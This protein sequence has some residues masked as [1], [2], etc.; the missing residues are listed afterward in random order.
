MA[1][2][3]KQKFAFNG[4]FGGLNELSPRSRRSM[5]QPSNSFNMEL[6]GGYL[7]PRRGYKQLVPN[8]TESDPIISMHPI[9]S[10]DETMHDNVIAQIFGD[11]TV[12]FKR[13][14]RAVEG[15]SSGGDELETLTSGTS[16]GG[17]AWAWDFFGLGR[18]SYADSGGWSMI[19]AGGK[20]LGIITALR[21]DDTSS[22]NKL[23]WLDKTQG[24]L[25]RSDTD[26]S[27]S[28]VLLY[29]LQSPF[30]LALDISNEMIYFTE[31]DAHRISRCKFNGGEHQVIYN[32]QRDGIHSPQWCDYDGTNNE[33][34]WTQRGGGSFLSGVLKA[35]NVGAGTITQ[36]FDKNTTGLQLER[37]WRGIAL[38]ENGGTDTDVFFVSAGSHAVWKYDKDVDSASMIVALST[39]STRKASPQD[40]RIDDG[41]KLYILS[42]GLYTHSNPF[43]RGLD[44][45][46][47]R[48][49]L[50]GSNLATVVSFGDENAI[51]AIEFDNANS[52][53]YW[54]QPVP[55]SS[56]FNATPAEP[57]QTEDMNKIMESASVYAYKRD[58]GK[59]Y[60]RKAG[61]E[62]P[63]VHGGVPAIANRIN[64]LEASV[65]AS[66]GTVF[67]YR[68]T[69]LDTFSG[70]ESDGSNEIVQTDSLGSNNTI[71]SR[72]AVRVFWNPP[73]TFHGHLGGTPTD[74][75][76]DKVRIYRRVLSPSIE[77]D[78][79]LAEEL[80][81]DH[82]E[83]ET[84]TANAADGTTIQLQD[85]GWGT[86][87]Y[88]ANQLAGLTIEI[89]DPGA[90]AT[91]P[92]GERAVIAS[93]T[94]ADEAVCTMV[95]SG[96]SDSV[97]TDTKYRIIGSWNDGKGATDL[98]TGIVVPVRHGVPP[99]SK[100]IW[101][102]RGRMYYVPENNRTLWYSEPA[103][104]LTARS[105]AEYVHQASDGSGNFE[106]LPEK[107]N[108]TGGFSDGEQ[109]IVFTE[110]AAYAIDDANIDTEGL[111]FVKIRDMPGC[112]SHHTI[113]NTDNGVFYANDRGVY[114]FNGS[115]TVNLTIDVP[116]T[117]KLIQKSVWAEN[118][119]NLSDAMGMYD[120]DMRRYFFWFTRID[121]AEGLLH[122]KN[123]RA[124]V[125]FLDD[126]GAIHP[127]QTAGEGMLSHAWARNPTG[128][129]EMVMGTHN[130][131]IVKLSNEK[132]EIFTDVGGDIKW[133]FQLPR[134]PT[135]DDT[136]ERHWYEAKVIAIGDLDVEAEWWIT[137]Q[138]ENSENINNDP[139]LAYNLLEDR[140]AVFYLGMHANRVNL[141]V[142]Y[143]KA[144]KDLNFTGYE[145]VWEERR[146]R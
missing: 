117:W 121:D 101:S 59:N 26:G 98:S 99:V 113:A 131:K 140:P 115:A 43:W 58:G 38:V 21:V 24:T 23:Y 109:N 48:C 95:G 139:P 83:E 143:F 100:Y 132:E 5:G 46:I 65:T 40:I 136:V 41:S 13:L 3:N 125:F 52:K 28:E 111:R 89:I 42:P 112:S 2:R 62:K 63:V 66:V 34:Y 82:G 60:F 141:F 127:W 78:W 119:G 74:V 29:G 11:N 146:K 129:M 97:R 14:V 10:E 51:Q 107:G 73:P 69:F 88:A 94:Q 80:P 79:L 39:P 144:P 126:G 124:L 84:A 145:L 61:L 53:L 27:D 44:S 85:I 22:P 106:V 37:S 104:P 123:R 96:F 142:Q 31:P 108:I 1:R 18:A 49:D 6:Y 122:R 15:T 4:P 71:G 70:L 64:T 47:H 86:S 33:I 19:A 92:A 118:T 54:A 81:I 110:N 32:K 30:S 137:A 105:G 55:T 138:V 36:V 91:M 128:D 17:T 135:T 133:G 90:T 134:V 93:N 67:G 20:S 102:H 76:A 9:P 8:T 103:D 57:V 75:F 7:R 87:G 56:V 77:N 12:A 120:P 16:D 35:T 45:S 68:I 114:L 130:G 116:Q 72:L 25:N 50:D